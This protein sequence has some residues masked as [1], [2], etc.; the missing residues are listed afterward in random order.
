MFAVI[1]NHHA[2]RYNKHIK[3]P[4]LKTG[5][6]IAL[7]FFRWP[8]QSYFRQTQEVAVVKPCWRMDY[9]GF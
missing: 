2:I 5:M 3:Y 7:E 1:D 9:V 6:K 8:R 4:A